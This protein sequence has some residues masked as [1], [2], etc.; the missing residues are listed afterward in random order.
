MPDN[1][2]ADVVTCPASTPATNPVE[3]PLS[4]TD[5]VIPRRVTIT[6]PDGHSGLTGIG[7]AFGH[8]VVIPSNT[9]AFISGNDHTFI[10]DLSGYPN[11]VSWSVKVCNLDLIAHVWQVIFEGDT[12][13]DASDT[14]PPQPLTTGQLA[15]AQAAALSGP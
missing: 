13:P 1:A 2:Y 10:F 14:T 7:L 6:I 11:G 15:Q 9:G 8:N 12:L 5:P 4:V 3:V